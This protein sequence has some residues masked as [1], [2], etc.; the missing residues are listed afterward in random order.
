MLYSSLAT[1][2]V[3]KDPTSYPGSY[4]AHRHAP[5]ARCEKTLSAAGH[6][7]SRFWVLTKY[8]LGVR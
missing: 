5:Y 4:S 8:P 1:S 2:A 7:A 3:I 6:V